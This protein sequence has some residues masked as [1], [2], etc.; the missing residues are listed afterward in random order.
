MEDQANLLPPKQPFE[1]SVTEKCGAFAAYVIAYLYIAAFFLYTANGIEWQIQK[2]AFVLLFCLG[3]WAFARGGKIP[4]ESWFWLGCLAAVAVG[5]IWGANRVW[6]SY[7]E[8]LLHGF[9]CYWVL[10]VTGRLM[11]GKSGRYLSLDLFNGFLAFPIANFPL[12]IRCVAATLRGKY[13]RKTGW[14]V[15]LAV[16]VGLVLLMTAAT[17]LARA[18]ATFAALTENF[19]ALFA[20]VRVNDFVL[21]LILSLPVGAWLFGLVAGAWR[22][23]PEKL[24]ARGEKIQTWLEKLRRVPQNVWNVLLLAFCLMYLVFFV[25]QGSYLFG[26]FTRTLPEGF[27]VAVYARRGFFELCGV[28]AL[29]NLLLWLVLRSTTVTRTG[30]ICCTLLTVCTLLL[31]VTALS[32]LALYI[33]CFGFTPRRLQSTWLACVLLAGGIATLIHLWTGK[34]TSRPWIWFSAATMAAL[35]LY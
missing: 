11:D 16:A 34:H 32:K 1:A 23:K 28:A 7:G 35:A 8:L 26:A 6:K 22:T 2:T 3:A 30:K 33:S 18:D 31:S 15:V 4:R 5:T 24:Q 19:F 14:P 29:N 20:P 10:T 27:S 12:R 17:L 21:R 9:A 25:V 13:Q